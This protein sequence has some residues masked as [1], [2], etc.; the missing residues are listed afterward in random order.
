MRPYTRNFI[1][2]AVSTLAILLLC[3]TV[4]ATSL[5]LTGSPNFGYQGILV[6]PYA[7]TLGTDPNLLVF[8]LDLHLDTSV[9]TTYEGNLSSPHTQVEEEAAFLASYSLYL[10]APR[11]DLVNNVEGPISMAIWQLMG[12]M[13][14]TPLDP[15]AQQYIHIAQSAYASGLITPAFLSSVNIWTPSPVGSVQR[16]VTAVRDDSMSLTI[17]PNDSITSPTPEP[18]SMVFLA[19]G[20]LL[21]ALSRVRRRQ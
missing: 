1:L 15:A 19:S 11:G 3:P 16:F 14:A 17:V 21:I 9:G 10:G 20:V 4:K 8:C 7:A 5:Q 18:G 2:T 6:G 12:T 13:G